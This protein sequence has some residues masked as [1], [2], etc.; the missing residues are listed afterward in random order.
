VASDNLFQR[1][2]TLAGKNL[3]LTPVSI[4][5][6]ILK[7][8]SRVVDKKLRWRIDLSVAQ[9]LQ[10]GSLSRSQNPFINLNAMTTSFLIL[11]NFSVG[12]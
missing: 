12:S 10:C 9:K 6:L 7:G 5:S 11:R 3:D 8:W 1:V 2:E 4:C